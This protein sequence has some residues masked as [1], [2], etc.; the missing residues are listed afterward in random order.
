MTAFADFGLAPELLQALA[1]LGFKTPTPVQSAAIPRIL[2][3]EQDLIALAE[4]GTGKTAAFSLPVIQKLDPLERSTQALILCPT[5]ELCLQISR[6]VTAFLR[7]LPQF[8]TV[9]VYGGDSI[10][11]QARAIKAGAAIVVA[12]PGRAK[13]LLE[14]KILAIDRIRFFILD[15]ADEM[16]DMGFKEELDGILSHAPESKQ[17]LLFSATMSR[18]VL[19][20]AKKYMRAPEE[21]RLSRQKSATKQ[22]A[23]EYYVVHAKDR[24]EALRRIL[25]ANPG[26]YGILF[27]RTRKDTQAIADKLIKDRYAAE[28]L[29]GDISQSLRT[30]IMQRFRNRHIRL[31][32]ATDVAARGID[33]SDLSHII[34]YDL[35]ETVETYIHRSGRTGRAEKSGVCVSILH[36]RELAVIPMLEREVGQSFT[37]RPVPLGPDICEKQLLSIVRTIKETPVDEKGLAPFLPAL[38]AELEGLDRHQLIA[39]LVAADFEHLIKLYR[40]AP[41]INVSLP[42]TKTSGGRPT[43]FCLDKGL[44]DTFS[45]KELLRMLNRAEGLNTA[46]IGRIEVNQHFTIFEIDAGHAKTLQSAVKRLRFGK[47]TV[48]LMTAAAAGVDFDAPSRD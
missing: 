19:A 37:R 47:R 21:I 30:Q 1:E 3:S 33:V 10:D 24:Y 25:D 27:C 36:L 17:T 11:R 4:T 32:V 22:I 34:N 39:G 35:P 9:A 43:A 6:D 46:K 20:I 26:I 13:D 41:D 48:R 45:A 44:K 38:E 42:A 14:R 12:T 28:A 5:R 15:E 31:L 18:G 23:H 7:F 2:A 16:L 8:K 29:H 40:D